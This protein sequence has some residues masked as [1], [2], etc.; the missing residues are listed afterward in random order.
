MAHISFGLASSHGPLLSTP[1]EQW[2]LRVQADRNNPAHPFRGGTY[3]F[4]E[5]A[6]LRKNENLQQQSRLEERQK[7]HAA[8]QKAI[9]TLAR[10][11]K[12]AA[13]DILVL[14]GN[15]QR[16]IFKESLTPAFSI[17][18][19]ESIDNVPL[20]EDELA[21]LKPGLA[22]AHWAN[23]PEEAVTY[24]CV[25]ELGEHLVES[26]VENGF[27]IATMKTLPEGP[28]GRASLPHA[29]GYL[30]R[31]IMND[32]PIPAVPIVLNTFFPPNQP[33]AARCIALGKAMA[34]AIESWDKDVRVG[35]LMSGGLSH[36]VI[37]EDFDGDVLS[38][39]KSNNEA[40]LASIP[41]HFFRSGTS[42]TKNWITG[43]G[44][45]AG[46]DLKM[47]LIDYVPCYRSE[48]GTGNA[49]AFATWQ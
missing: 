18:H 47:K 15:D 30:Y 5:L 39:M 27:D 32:V 26:L 33:K 14:I 13:P 17:L 42:E 23:V 46:T 16:E 12:E 3:T 24:P 10:E 38:A 2:E 1:P 28:K 9:E 49:M 31:R 35:I 45:L 37:D 11:L 40:R 43:I 7:R 25:P 4:D 44:A 20:S 36:F 48:A 8:C 22:I 34:R 6:E 19:G 29:Y 21:R 41:S